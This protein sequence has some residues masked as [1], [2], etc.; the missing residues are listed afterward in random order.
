MRKAL[1][2][3]TWLMAVLVVLPA[4]FYGEEDWRGARD[5]AACQKELAA[6]GESLDLR[7]LAPPGK[8]EDDLSK[9]PIF[10]P[11]YQ[12]EIDPNAPINQISI[13]LNGPYS[14]L[15]PKPSNYLKGEALD[16]AAWQKYYRSLPDSHLPDQTGTPAQ[17]VL[18]VLSRFDPQMQQIDSAVSN[19]N[20]YFP[21]DY[22]M[23][24]A[25]PLGPI[26]KM[27]SVAQLLQ[28][29]G[30]A[31]LENQETDL[32]EKDFLFSF[33]I[34]QPLTKGCLMFNYLVIIGVRAIDNSLVWE[35]LH[36]RAWNDAQL[37]EIDFVL[38]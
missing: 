31:H 33:R 7:V 37:H 10:A 21:I 23:P 35:G 1:I 13:G 20:A 9:A 30:V 36:R 3:L 4:L 26:T 14:D 28:L 24:I 38:A 22:E 11:L 34:N 2:G 15:Y 17:E 16:L 18:Q 27:I 25:T 32:A 6:K 29:R 19:P 8:P 5:W 12:K